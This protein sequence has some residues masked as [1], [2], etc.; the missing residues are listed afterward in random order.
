MSPGWKFRTTPLA[1]GLAIAVLR[2]AGSAS[3]AV[4]GTL[5]K[6][7]CAL[8]K[9]AEIQALASNAKIGG[10]VADASMAPLG[11]G[12]SYTWGPR[13]REWG[14]SALTITVMDASKAWP[15]VSPDVLQQGVLAKVKVGGPNASQVA[16]VGDAAAF[17]FEARS[18][19]AMAEAYFKAKGLHLSLSF[20]AGD[21]LSNKDK[22]I[23]LL[24]SAAARL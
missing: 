3:E 12:C 2:L 7:P 17:T 20:H 21:S 6:D 22:L 5:P 18:S 14:E 8:L 15:G 16:A 24:K 23:A 19:N 11:V 13:T 1:V 10:G 9:P 4:A